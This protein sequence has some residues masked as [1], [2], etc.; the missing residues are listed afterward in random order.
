MQLETLLDAA[1]HL[2]QSTP[3]LN[4]FAPWPDDL[5]R[6][7]KPI[8]PCAA[9]GHIQQLADTTPLVAAIQSAAPFL[10]WRQSYTADQVGQ[11]FLDRY[12]YVELFGPSGQFHSNQL[13]GYIAFW[14]N[15]LQYGWHHHEAEELYFGL[16]GAALFHS[17][18]KPNAQ[19]V[20]GSTR[21][22]TS[23]EVHAMDTQDLPFLCYVLW[24]GP[25]LAELPKMSE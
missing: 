18:S 1:R 7:D 24:R 17:K 21:L 12:G 20:P 15:G 14:G 19:L 2:H 22:H 8:V 23:W 3:R 4:E 5:I 25:G 16:H 10:S 13:R 6:Q 11:D 9:I